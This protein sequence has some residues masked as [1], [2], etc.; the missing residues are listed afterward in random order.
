[1]IKISKIKV[2]AYIRISKREKENNSIS[3]QK[4]LI[5]DYIKTQANMEIYDYYIDNG[6]S[7]TDFNRPELKRMLKDIS[8]N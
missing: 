4:D 5:D 1:M 7:G 8:N 2:A 3:N 6:Y